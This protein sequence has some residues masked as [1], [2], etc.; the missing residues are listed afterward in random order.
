MRKPKYMYHEHNILRLTPAR[1]N[2]HDNNHNNNH[3]N[4]NHNNNN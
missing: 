1:N 2:S 3:N 4:N